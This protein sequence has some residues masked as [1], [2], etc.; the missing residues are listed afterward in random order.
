MHQ[1]LV[2]RCKAVAASIVI[3]MEW[4]I[5]FDPEVVRLEEYDTTGD[6]L[7]KAMELLLGAADYVAMQTPLRPFDPRAEV[8]II[9]GGSLPFPKSVTIP[10][11]SAR[12]PFRKLPSP[13]QVLLAGND[14]ICLSF[15]PMSIS[16]DFPASLT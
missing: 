12:K 15:R 4:E 13:V 1:L 9:L 5:L 3:T 8:T 2:E 6:A 7:L 11:I 14:P 10:V 16:N